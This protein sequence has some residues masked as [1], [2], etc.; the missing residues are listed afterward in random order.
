MKVHMKVQKRLQV[1]VHEGWDPSSMCLLTALACTVLFTVGFR[2][3]AHKGYETRCEASVFV[4]KA[5][6]LCKT[7]WAGLGA[8]VQ[9]HQ[10]CFAV[11]VIKKFLGTC[12]EDV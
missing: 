1:R 11:L 7:S 6:G 9:L 12:G 3:H 8:Q 10:R 4:Q 5:F 2:V